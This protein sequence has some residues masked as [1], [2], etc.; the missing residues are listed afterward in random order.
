M[1]G[2]KAKQL[3]HFR[4]MAAPS[5]PSAWRRS[6]STTS[7]R[8]LRQCGRPRPDRA[9]AAGAGFSRRRS[10]AWRSEM[11]R[12]PA[13]PKKRLTRLQYDSGQMLD[14][15]RG[16]SFD[17]Q[18]PCVAVQEPQSRGV[19]WARGAVD[20]HSAA[21]GGRFRDLRCRPSA[22]MISDEAKPCV[23][24]RSVRVVAMKSESG[25]GKLRAGLLIKGVLMASSPP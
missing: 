8:R 16:R 9:G 2:R 14:L 24:K 23:F 12:W 20:L 13:Q 19:F 17:P 15:E 3:A 21:M 10:G 1:A 22:E 18:P 5:R 25:R 6:S 11:R 7:G 4:L